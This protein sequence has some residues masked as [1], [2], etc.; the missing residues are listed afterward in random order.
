MKI[1]F[2]SD[3]FPPE[4]NAPASR[5]FEHCRAWAR[6]GYEVTVIT[7]APN[8]PTGQVFAG[9][10]NRWRSLEAVD[11]IRVIRVWTYVAR[12]AGVVR[13]I[14][15]YLSF[16]A[17]AIVAGMLVRRPDIIIATSP[18]FFTAVAGRA[19][20][21]LRRRPWVFELRDL[22]PESI[23]AVGA[24]RESIGLRLLRTLEMHLYRHCRGVISVTESFRA[25]LVSRGIDA[26]KI[27]VVTNGADLST[28]APRAKDQELAASLG[29]EGKFVAGYV[30]THGMAHGLETLLETADIL[31]KR[32]DG[33]R[34][35]ILLLGDGAR[36]PE[37]QRMAAER[38]LEN[39]L[40]IDLVPKAQVPRY[41]S[42]L[43]AAIIHLRPTE[44][45][46]S[47]IPSKL[48]ECMAMGI[49]VLHG[50]LGESAEI[51]QR[52]GVG[53]V[54]PPGD[55]EALARLISELEGDRGRLAT[56]GAA[57]LAAAPRYDRERQARKMLDIL[58]QWSG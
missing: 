41:W 47:V 36:K 45:F 39:V 51:V 46:K 13:R 10:R 9:Y 22:W 24:M 57:G 53:V 43:D 40:F 12:N 2:L 3:N 1:L 32:P 20:G 26:A 8:F 7:C 31:R 54:F 29:L 19:L 15:D 5:T 56:L 48:F 55:H 35:R 17:G 27:A 50:V 16:M 6:A 42:I 18:Q 14:A 58:Q 28:F 49:P 30:G 23:S 38:G 33:E 11:G 21:T 34:Y 25:H 44:L 52:E 4:V 37:L